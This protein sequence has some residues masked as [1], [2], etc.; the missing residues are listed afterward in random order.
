MKKNVG[1]SLIAGMEEAL[2][3]MKGKRKGAVVHRVSVPEK[4]DVKAIRQKMHLSREQFATRFG[5]SPRTLQ[6]WEQGNRKPQKS[7]RILLTVLAENPRAVEEA[8]AH[9]S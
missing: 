2:A 7:A 5:F 4:I 8:L 6:H 1:D 3:Y 9:I